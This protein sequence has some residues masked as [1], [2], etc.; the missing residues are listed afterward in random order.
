[1]PIVVKSSSD[2]DAEW[3]DID[4]SSCSKVLVPHPWYELPYMEVDSGLFYEDGTVKYFDFDDGSNVYKVE[5][6]GTYS[7]DTAGDYQVIGVESGLFPPGTISP[8]YAG[9]AETDWSYVGP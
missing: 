1:M 4:F 5:A 3:P 7:T 6:S 2:M 8:G 9:T